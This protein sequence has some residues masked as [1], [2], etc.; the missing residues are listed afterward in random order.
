MVI[1]KSKRLLKPLH[2]IQYIQRTPIRYKITLVIVLLLLLPM[3][4]VGIYFYVNISS[5]LTKNANENLSNLIQQANGN[6]ENSFKIIDTTS[7]HFLSNKN[8]RSWSSSDTSFKEDIYS[9]FS[10]KVASRKTLNTV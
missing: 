7:L 6:I 2:I 9:L 1:S 3:L 4:L 5:V 8:I 10:I